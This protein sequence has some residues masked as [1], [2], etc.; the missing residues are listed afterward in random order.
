MSSHRAWVFGQGK[1]ILGIE[2]ANS[3]MHSTA[4]PA[5]PFL[6]GL[7]SGFHT[8]PNMYDEV[9]VVNEDH[10]FPG[11]SVSTTT[12]PQFLPSLGL[13]ESAVYHSDLRVGLHLENTGLTFLFS[14]PG[15]TT[16]T[17]DGSGNLSASGASPTGVLTAGISGSIAI[18]GNSARGTISLLTGTTGMISGAQATIT[19]AAPYAQT[20]VVTCS[21]MSA[22]QFPVYTIPSTTGFTLFSPTALTASTAYELGYIV[23]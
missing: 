19:F 6:G 18:S 2:Y 20:P 4:P 10:N 16:W 9:L 15:A 17:I 13:G 12:N 14:K 23:L 5:R 1:G 21:F 3:H 22:A 7:S 8:V 11:G